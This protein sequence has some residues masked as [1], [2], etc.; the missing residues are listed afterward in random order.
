MRV[1]MPFVDQLARRHADHHKTIRG[2][3]VACR[4]SKRN[5]PTVFER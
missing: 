1:D 2:R 5:P 4:N 3:S